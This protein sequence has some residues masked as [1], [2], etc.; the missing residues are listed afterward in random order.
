ME[1]KLDIERHYL[2]V[3]CWDYTSVYR[4][5]LFENIAIPLKIASQT[6]VGDKLKILLNNEYD[7]AKYVSD[8]SEKFVAKA[9][10]KHFQR[11]L[12]VENLRKKL[13]TQPRFTF[14]YETVPSPGGHIYFEG[15]AIRIGSS[16]IDDEILL[17][18]RHIDDLVAEERRHQSELNEHLE[19]ERIQNEVFMALG[20]NYD[21][22]FR[23]DLRQD[24]YI[25]ILCND[26]IKHYY[27][28]NPSAKEMLNEVCKNIVAPR[29]YERMLNFVDL[30]TLAERLKERDFVEAECIT[31]EGVW[32]RS[33]LIVKR[34]NAKGTA[35]NILYVTQIINDEKHYEEHLVAKAE[36]ADL[37]NRTKNSFISQVAHDIR[38]PMNSILGFLEIAESNL[39][40]CEYDKVYYN[41]EKTRSAGEFLKNLVNDILDISRIEEGKFIL[42]T[43]SAKLSDMLENIRNNIQISSNK[44]GHTF[45]MEVKDICHNNIVTDVLRFMQI[46][47]NVLTNAIKYTP[48]GGKIGLTV[49]QE[50][51]PN[52][53]R[54]RTVAKISDTGIGMT[55]EFMKNM[56]NAFERATDTRINKVSGYGLGLTIVKQFVD[57]MGGSIEAESELG[58]GT[59]FIIKLETPYLDESASG[60]VDEVSIDGN[61]C[62]G[63]HLLVAED[64]ELNRE[65]ITEL[66][67]MNDITCECTEDGK[68]C[69][70]RFMSAEEG[71][72]D[73]ILMD[74]QMPI[75]NGI[76]A[77][78]KIRSL[79]M[80]W[81]KTVPII[82]MTANA[83][84]E[85]VKKCLDVGMNAHLSKPVDMKQVL[86]ALAKNI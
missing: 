63:K 31:K 22:I 44:K 27:S 19:R 3:L 58:K 8:Y 84:K 64:N 43:E 53:G 69:I 42:Q 25:K 18:F 4:V 79:P 77:T 15:Q 30:K 2:N 78:R 5:K 34:R 83:M 11:S 65:V 71:T 51:I 39:S 72:F 24:T 17:G 75:M 32:H 56:F 81:A 62:R 23:I 40:K 46:Y 85:D 10:R 35:T 52:S 80:P 55:E 76:D 6:F 20:S 29:H 48:T 61:T 12:T 45:T 70:E 13:R 59:T 37:A 74:I 57:M 1:N 33:R 86:K 54:V 50:E 66:L 28:D 21:A 41:L 38:T 68:S 47:T 73:A 7:F 36:Y 67:L 9:D 14:R 16:L 49:F 60:I 26:K 82:A